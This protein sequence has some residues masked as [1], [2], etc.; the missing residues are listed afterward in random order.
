MD[1]FLKSVIL[2]EDIIRG[3]CGKIRDK[4]RDLKAEIER[5]ERDPIFFSRPREY[6]K[7]CDG[8]YCSLKGDCDHQDAEDKKPSLVCF[9]VRCLAEKHAREVQKGVG[10]P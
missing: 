7:F 10:L 8:Y 4:I 1:S 9:G 3:E 5:L 2:E 6:C